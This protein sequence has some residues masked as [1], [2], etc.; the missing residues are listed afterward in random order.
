MSVVKDR[1][2]AYGHIGQIP[3]FAIAAL[4]G[5]LLPFL[6]HLTLGHLFLPAP[7]AM[8]NTSQEYNFVRNIFVVCGALSVV[9]PA[10]GAVIFLARNGASSFWAAI[11]C[12]GLAVGSAATMVFLSAGHWSFVM[13]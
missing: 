12:A 3:V 1:F 13:R 4:I 11:L 5:L 10:V 7:E 9:L 2:T 8:R 6:F